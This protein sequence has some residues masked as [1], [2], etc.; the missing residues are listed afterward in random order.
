MK[1]KGEKYF[2]LL[3]V[4][5]KMPEKCF[6][7]VQYSSKVRVR[8]DGWRFI[9]YQETQIQIPSGSRQVMQMGT[10]GQG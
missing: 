7:D 5:I 6:K 1:K 4:E 8:H 3:H 10:E 2:D 9:L